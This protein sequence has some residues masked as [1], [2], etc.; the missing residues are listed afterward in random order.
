MLRKIISAGIITALS[1]MAGPQL[2]AQMG[3]TTSISEEMTSKLD[4]LDLTD[5]QTNKVLYINK[6]AADS[7]DALDKKVGDN[8]N[9]L[10]NKAITSEL[11]GIMVQRDKSLRAILTPEQMK[12][13]EKNRVKQLASFRTLVMIPLLDLTDQQI[14]QIFAINLKGVESMQKELDKRNQSK[15]TTSDQEARHIITNGFKSTDKDFEA[16]LSP[17][18]QKIYKDNEELLVDAVR[19]DKKVKNP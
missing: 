16:I 6:V 13:F 15:K 14:P 5:N 9:I 8:S 11:I 4:Y 18:Q 1:F 10:N 7:L 2:K 3:S 12:A 17:S 19:H